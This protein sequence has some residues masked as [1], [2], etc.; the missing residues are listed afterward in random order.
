MYVRV[1][2]E[3]WILAYAILNILQWPLS[4][5]QVLFFPNSAQKT[6]IMAL[7]FNC[8]PFCFLFL[9]QIPLFWKCCQ[10]QTA[11]GIMYHVTQSTVGHPSPIGAGSDISQS[12]ARSQ[13]A[14]LLQEVN[15]VMSWLTQ[16]K[17]LGLAE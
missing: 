14:F 9:W 7:K 6:R 5:M 16:W 2:G 3:F 15:W 10:P 13:L 11:L 12:D 4:Y 1:R 8:P 17:V